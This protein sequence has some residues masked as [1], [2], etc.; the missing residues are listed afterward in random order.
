[1]YITPFTYNAV[2][3]M[4]SNQRHGIVVVASTAGKLAVARCPA[5]WVDDQFCL[6]PG[7]E[8]SILSSAQRENAGVATGRQQQQQQQAASGKLPLPLYCIGVDGQLCLF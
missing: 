5:V 6:G 1:M 2:V 3:T 8:S 7:F 4:R